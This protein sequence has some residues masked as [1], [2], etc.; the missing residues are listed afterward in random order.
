MNSGKAARL[1]QFA[2][3]AEIFGAH[4]FGDKNDLPVVHYEMF[5][6]LVNRF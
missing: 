5:H 2:V 6:D 3:K 1:I 4:K